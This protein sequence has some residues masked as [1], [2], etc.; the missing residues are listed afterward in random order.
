MP[1][2][3]KHCVDLDFHNVP[4]DA[5]FHATCYRRV[6]DQKHPEDQQSVASDVAAGSS[7]SETPRE[8]L[9]SGT[10]LPVASAGPVLPPLCIIC[11]RKDK[12]FT[13]GG[14]R[15]KDHLTQAVTLSAGKQNTHRHTHIHTRDFRRKTI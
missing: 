6:I 8:K 4:Q 2:T 5:G 12:Y 10:G 11:K 1:K 15:H 7:T 14:K 9:R 3:Y 13:K